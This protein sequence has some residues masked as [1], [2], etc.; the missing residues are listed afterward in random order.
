M[1][2]L[3]AGDRIRRLAAMMRFLSQMHE[4]GAEPDLL[5]AVLQAA[6]VWFDLDVRAYRRELDGRDRLA[7]WLP[8]ADLEGEPPE[9]HCAALGLTTAPRRVTAMADFDRLGWH[10][11][12]REV[13][14]LPIAPAGQVRWVLIV[15]GTIDRDEETALALMARTAAS[16]L[17][18]L[19]ARDARALAD[20]LAAALPTADGQVGRV[21]GELLQQLMAAVSAVRGALAIRRSTAPQPDVLAAV[22]DFGS[23]GPSWDDLGDQAVMTAERL[24]VSLP[25]G[26]GATGLID[27]RSRPE[28]PFGVA[29]A[30][31]VAA[32]VSVVR[33]WLAGV[34]VALAATEFETAPVSER[35]EPS[36]TVP[37][38]RASDL[39]QAIHQAVGSAR[40]ISLT[41]GILLVGVSGV[42]REA[43]AKARRLAVESMRAE[44][45]SSDLL[46]QLAT[47][48]L[49]A[50]LPRTTREGAA[51]A[52]RRLSRRLERLAHEH[53]LPGFLLR[54][55]SYPDRALEHD[56]A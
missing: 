41:G 2:P 53:Q 4:I 27:L 37:A 16:V 21:A 19:A 29:E 22:G 49:A 36:Q 43:E 32:G 46:G 9:L 33:A 12:Q 55:A 38:Q 14:L 47:G 23:P 45:R 56:G 24:A 13:V 15:P 20:R 28:K 3:D 34:A 18:K 44:L 52:A 25:L 39:D 17:E 35:A 5:Q 50:L 31:F 8:G 51:K 54:Q 42:E 10:Q 7:L 6:A 30:N 1:K 11:A 40:K 26:S 48:D